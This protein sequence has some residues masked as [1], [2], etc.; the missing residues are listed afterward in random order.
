MRI[1]P[2]YLVAPLPRPPSIPTR[3]AFLIATGTFVAGT[4]VGGACG[5]S[6]GAAA[7]A[8]PDAGAEPDLAPSG[9]AELDY[10]RNLAVK[11]PLDELFAKAAVF[12]STRVSTYKDDPILWQGVD[13]MTKEI[14][15]NPARRVDEADIGIIITQI[16]G[17]A[18]PVEPSLRDRLPALRARKA[19]ERRRK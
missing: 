4:A 18:H 6:L 11:A 16:E 13:R 2:V 9:D 8:Q 19:E 5:Y 14:I 17:V 10:W 7:T 12:L 1:E 15:E 3:R